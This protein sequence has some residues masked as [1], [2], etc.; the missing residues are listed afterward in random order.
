VVKIWA[1]RWRVGLGC[2][3]TVTGMDA[4]MLDV[5]GWRPS[6]RLSLPE[7]LWGFHWFVHSR[8]HNTGT[9]DGCAGMATPSSRVKLRGR[10]LVGSWMRWMARLIWTQVLW[11]VVTWG[12]DAQ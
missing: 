4:W 12:P 2:A 3:G 6:V 8:G 5:W 1:H 9:G 7:C 10:R 11:R